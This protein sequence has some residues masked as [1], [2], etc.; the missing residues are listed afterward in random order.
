[1]TRPE[2]DDYSQSYEELLSDP[3]RNHFGSGDSDFFHE[4]K[5]DLIRG[6]FRQRKINMSDLSYLD[7][8]CGQGKLISLLSGDFARAAGCDVSQGMI[9]HASEL[10]VRLQENPR[11]IPFKA[12]EFDVV[13][14]VGVYHH[15]LTADRIA[16]T[17]A[18]SRVLK[19][20]GVFI[21]I[22]HNPLNPVT[23]LIVGRS[24]VDRYAQLLG[25][26]EA[27]A[28]LSI[29]GFV[30]IATSYFLF[31]PKSVYKTGGAAV[32]RWLSILPFGGQYAVFGR[33]QADH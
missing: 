13:S 27:K 8:G 17:C 32:E 31:F 19:P 16:L 10:E 11:E 14:A 15:V 3:I 2:F 24:P 6:Y 1:M 5:S 4:R 26:R 28:L 9:G 22:E 29:A 23:K 21:V 33:K 12:A 30:S 20:G 18:I 25:T 7:V